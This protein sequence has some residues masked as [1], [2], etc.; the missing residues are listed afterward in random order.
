M[1]CPSQG[2]EKLTLSMAVLY[3][4][5]TMNGFHS[6]DKAYQTIQYVRTEF[7]EKWNLVPSREKGYCSGPPTWPP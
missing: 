4:N 5:F 1:K 7:A 2:R 6:H 3:A